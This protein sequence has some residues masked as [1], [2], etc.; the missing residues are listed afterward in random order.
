MIPIARPNLDRREEKAV[1]GVLRSGM[2][3]QGKKVTQLEKKFARFIGCKYAIAT[4]SGTTALHLA[5]LALGLEKDDEIITS[6]FTF[7]ASAN[8]CLFIGAKPIFV[9]IDEIDFNIN[10]D[11]IEAA[12]TKKTK[13]IIPIH[14]FGAPANMPA[15]TKI[16]RKHRLL[17]IEDACQAHGA[18]IKKKK[19]GN[20]GTL[21]CFSLYA[22]KNMVSGE[23]G[24]ITTNSKRLAEKCQLLRSHGS[25]TRYHHHSLGFNF[26]MTDIEAA[27]ALEQLKKLPQTNRKRISNAK[28]LNKKIK[29]LGVILPKITSE[30]RHVVH[31][32]T[33]RIA[34]NCPASREKII[35]ALQKN[36]IGH[37]I[38][39]PVP[40]HKQKLYQKLGYKNKLPITEKMAKQVLSLPIHSLVTKRDLGLIVKIINQICKH[41]K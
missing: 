24:I 28:H 38:F 18:L 26:R 36:S 33:I 15:I 14:L 34:K 21:G 22:T 6:A 7:I 37:G 40:I 17:I 12:I 2:L 1:L 32:Y 13:A 5:L 8:A 4:S 35:E 3:A 10:P 9:D 23:G 19:V 31:Q 11:L 25:K 30:P 20:W 41:K 16:A 27:I 29:A 39:Y